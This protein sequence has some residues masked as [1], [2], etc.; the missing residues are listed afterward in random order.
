MSPVTGY[1]YEGANNTFLGAKTGLTWRADFAEVVASGVDTDVASIIGTVGTGMTVSQSASNLVIASGTTANQDTIV[2]LPDVIEPHGFRIAYQAT[3]SQRIANNNFFVELV[4]VIGDGL[5]VTVSSATVAVVT[6]PNNPFTSANV[7]Q[8]MYIG[9]YRGTGT[10]PPNRYAIASVSG[11][12]VTF[13]IAGGSAGSGTASVFGWNYHH[14]LYDGTSNVSAKYDAQTRGWASGD[15]SVGVNSTTTGHICV[16][17]AQEFRSAF[18]DTTLNVTSAMSNRT[19]RN[20]FV[21]TDESV[22][23]DGLYVQI[24]AANGTSAPASNTNFSVGFVAMADFLPLDVAIADTRMPTNRSDNLTVN[25]NG[26]TLT[27]SPN[28]S[29][30]GYYLVT[31]ASTNAAAIK[32]SAGSILELTISNPTATA[33][34]V[35]LYNKASSP[36]VGTDVPIITYPIPANTTYTYVYGVSGKRFTTGIAIAVTA[37]MADS[38]TANAVAGVKVNATYN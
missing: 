1:T 13:T 15:S 28:V 8:S 14:V 9:M 26:G 34:Y 29:Q 38:D 25:V 7:G 33:A 24:R 11:D 27:A 10:L 12:N 2:R 32:T 6:I 35:K 16:I 5:T 20:A 22:Y 18:L 23:G 31:T 30:S 3:L 17:S 19:N 21:P 37:A 36:T 4:D